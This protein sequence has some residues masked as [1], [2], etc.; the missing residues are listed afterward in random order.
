MIL[1]AQILAS[2]K[3]VSLGVD[4]LWI[5]YLFWG[6]LIAYTAL[7]GIRAVVAT[8][9]IQAGVLIFFLFTAFFYAFWTQPP[10]PFQKR[11]SP[12]LKSADGFSCP[13]SFRSLNKIWD[14]A[15]SPRNRIEF[16]RKRPLAPP[17]LLFSSPSFPSTLESPACSSVLTALLEAAS[18]WQPLP[19]QRLPLSQPS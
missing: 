14:S 9:M 11:T 10:S 15:V 7:G 5:F 8:D 13:F 18:S 19:T 3:I 17:S 12:P 4:N 2:N 6:L 1:I 16:S